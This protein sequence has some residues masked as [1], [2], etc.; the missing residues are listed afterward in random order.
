MPIENGEER[1][2]QAPLLSEPG[3]QRSG[4]LRNI[5]CVP[6]AQGVNHSF[7]EGLNHIGRF[8]DEAGKLSPLVYDSYPV[9]CPRLNKCDIC[10]QNLGGIATGSEMA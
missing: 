9:G 7:K 3:S 10:P 2:C 4:L 6:D 5:V 1:W 8:R